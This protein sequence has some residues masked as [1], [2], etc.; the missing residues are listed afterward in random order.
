[1]ERLALLDTRLL[2]VY[3]HRFPATG[4]RP[5]IPGHDHPWGFVS[6]VLA[7]G[8]DE[9]SCWCHETPHRR[10]HCGLRRARAV[11]RI[12]VH[13]DGCLTLC[14]RGPKRQDWSWQRLPK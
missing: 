3:L 5:I 6:V 10:G 8:Y 4:G 9:A 1:M 12:R 14:I 7:G 13:P 2:G 11:H